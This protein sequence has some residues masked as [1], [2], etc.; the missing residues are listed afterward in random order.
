MLTHMLKILIYLN[1]NTTTTASEFKFAYK[2]QLCW[3]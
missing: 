1:F 3:V 2:L